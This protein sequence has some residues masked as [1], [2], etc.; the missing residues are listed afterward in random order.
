MIFEF[1]MGREHDGP[2]RFLGDFEG[3]LQTGVPGD[4]SSSLGW[5]R[6]LMRP[7]TVSADR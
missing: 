1:R 5:R 2:L 4:R 6:T 7:T 3:I